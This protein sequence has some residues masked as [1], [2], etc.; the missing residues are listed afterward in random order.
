MRLPLTPSADVGFDPLGFSNHELG[1]FDSAK[2]HMAWMREAEIKHARL[3][4]VAAAGWPLAELLNKLLGGWALSAT[5]GRAP[6]LFNGN[7]S[8]K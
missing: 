3:A 5:N 7:M 6:S 8:L 4:M 1:P 2:E